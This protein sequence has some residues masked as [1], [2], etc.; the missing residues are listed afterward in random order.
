MFQPQAPAP[1]DFFY[2]LD[3]STKTF[4]PWFPAPPHHPQM[5]P[6]TNC[7]VIQT[8]AI[9]CKGLLHYDKEESNSTDV[10]RTLKHILRLKGSAQGRTNL[11]G[12]PCPGLE[13]KRSRRRPGCR[14]WVEKV[15]GRPRPE[16][17]HSARQQE[18]FPRA[19]EIQGWWA[20]PREGWGRGGGGHVHCACDGKPSRTEISGGWELAGRG[21]GTGNVP[22]AE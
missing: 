6:G 1:C 21:Q 12:F 18:R 11:E 22:W 2:I 7:T 15:P 20:V 8:E 14:L 9:S 17:G 3:T 19:Q 13:F 5:K 16:L 4:S 10:K